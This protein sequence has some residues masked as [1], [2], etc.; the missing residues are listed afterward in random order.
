MD[1]MSEVLEALAEKL[2]TN[3]AAL[4]P[5]YIEY[6]HRCAIAKVCA[7]LALLLVVAPAILYV[8][9]R[10]FR[11]ADK[12][13]DHVDGPMVKVLIA[14]FG[15]I[16]AI[17]FAAIGADVL[18]SGIYILVSPEGYAIDVIISRL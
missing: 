6:L 15:S 7:G 8:T 3:V 5:T 14:I 12:I 9:I 11:W 16:T 4:A 10:L 17:V 1:K 18:L 2:G 13:E